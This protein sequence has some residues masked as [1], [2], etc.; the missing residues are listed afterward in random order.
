[1]NVVENIARDV[2]CSVDE[3]VGQKNLG[4]KVG[5]KKYTD[6]QRGIETL[7]DILAELENLVAIPGSNLRCL[8][9]PKIYAVSMTLGKA[10]CL[11]GW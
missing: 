11:M 8:N 3:L 7:T 4:K 1:M 10:W 9:S 5:Y 2:G 6:N